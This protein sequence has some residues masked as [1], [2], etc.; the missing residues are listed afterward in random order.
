MKIIILFYVCLLLTLVVTTS[1]AL[2]YERQRK[3]VPRYVTLENYP[4]S[5]PIFKSSLDMT[6]WSYQPTADDVAE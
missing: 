5:P 1:D 6:G 3:Y 4:T 2:N